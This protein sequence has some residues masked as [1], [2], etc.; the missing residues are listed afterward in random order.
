MQVEFSLESYIPFVNILSTS[1][2]YT[3]GIHDCACNNEKVKI[4]YEM[5]EKLLFIK[6]VL[7]LLKLS[8]FGFA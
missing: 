5:W 6:Y 3:W 4:F 8:L 2:I 1:D 7:S